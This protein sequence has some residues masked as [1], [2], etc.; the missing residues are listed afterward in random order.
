[1]FTDLVGY[2]ARSQHDE[3]QA[4]RF[5]DEQRR[6]LRPKFDEHRGREV[7]TIG[8]AFLVEFDSALNAA[9]CAV[10]I[11]RVLYERNLKEPGDSIDVRI[12]IHL[13][14][15]THDHD[16]IFGDAVNVASR[17]Y[18]LADPGGICLSE[19]VYAQIRGELDLNVE[20]LPST[21]LKNVSYPIDLFR[22]LL[23]WSERG[24]SAI[25]PWT[26]REE[27]LDL[28]QKALAASA[29]GEEGIVMLTGEVGIG[30][31]RLADEALGHAT[32]AGTRVQRGRCP[33][34][35][36]AAPYAPWIEAFRQFV[37]EAPVPLLYRV[38][39]SNAREIARILPEITDKVGPVPT[40]AAGEPERARHQFLDAIGQFVEGLADAG[41][42][43]IFLDDLHWADPASTLLLRYL[44]PRLRKHPVLILG[45][46]RKTEE[47]ENRDF[48]E[49][50]AELHRE[51]LV[52]T[53]PLGRFDAAQVGHIIREMFH[54]SEVSKEFRELVH[55]RTGG[56]PL[57]VEEVLRALVRDRIIYWAGTGWE[58]R[59]VDQI[60][61]PE[62][63]K[64]II[65]QRLRKFDD[66]SIDLLR[67]ASVIG[68]DFDFDLLL[69]ISGEE[70]ARM[71]D[72]IESLLRGQLIQEV[73]ASHGRSIYLFSDHPTRDVLYE[74]ASLVRRRR[75][76]LK[77]A[78]AIENLGE[79]T[80]RARAPELAHHFL[81]GNDIGKARE[82]SV[83]AGEQA[84]AVFAHAESYRHF[85][86][87]LEMAE[88]EGDDASKARALHRMGLE[89]LAL[90]QGREA[91][92]CLTDA[93]A[94]YARISLPQERA[95]ALSMA[96]TVARETQGDVELALRLAREAVATLESGPES[97]ELA[98][99]LNS[100]G[101]ILL[102]TRNFDE[103]RA[104]LER[105]VPLAQ[106]Y[107]DVDSA[108]TALQFLGNSL[109]W[110]RKEEGLARTVEGA[111]IAEEGGAQRTATKFVNL[112]FS[113]GWI[114][115]DP[116]A[117]IE[118]M[119]RG[120]RAAER[121]GQAQYVDFA[122]A[123]KSGLFLLLGRTNEAREEARAALEGETGVGSTMSR[124]LALS[125]YGALEALAGEYDRAREIA[126]ELRR[127][128]VGV[129]VPHF[130]AYL[131][132]MVI[133]RAI[134]EQTQDIEAEGELEN[135][136]ATSLGH[137]K[138]LQDVRMLG[139]ALVAA[140]EGRIRSGAKDAQPLLDRLEE[141]ASELDE[142]WARASRDVLQG[143]VLRARRDLPGAVR[144]FRDAADA[145][146][147]LSD[148]YQEAKARELLG[149]ALTELGQA[150]EAKAAFD[151]AIELLGTLNAQVRLRRVQRLLV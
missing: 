64:E 93:A 37:Q 132:S 11:Q 89:A 122:R 97:Q 88:E 62:G 144:A 140:G 21:L 63:V 101:V 20:K 65:L 78:Q 111:R 79:K 29:R 141:L 129:G 99:A 44:G 12:G 7:K 53:V 50:L 137:V 110:N 84:A 130:V 91:L 81:Q 47:E 56:N 26:D 16:D 87:A 23:P 48:R 148:P 57:L 35:D 24:L 34:G 92:K 17:I 116:R 15:V 109:P 128:S 72:A 5:L 121:R 38:L 51:R 68:Y 114:R 82:Y 55:S 118:A 36:L 85:R 58:R 126:A 80:A 113:L 123:S 112:G 83:L 71:L 77:I 135:L 46:Y 32:K 70:E 30:K 107:H 104:I 136:L 102:A 61:I 18:P 86:T 90:N 54:T 142:S 41:P 45:A 2:T 10:A 42:L 133:D 119:E 108:A 150:V 115:G 43:V 28:V 127:I 143:E 125:T 76:H 120:R 138:D 95:A 131:D 60:E 67:L 105:A 49:A 151:R 147:Q 124:A 14:E 19:P 27:V 1:M 103:G 66:K 59:S 146:K 117:G 145:W 139:F 134:E 73:P 149:S 69:A 22:A 3:P 40:P 9:S 98:V 96:A 75:L 25:L 52:S 100:L 74:Q 94:L 39:G 6:L 33:P 4:L 13:G 31:T 106:K 8:D